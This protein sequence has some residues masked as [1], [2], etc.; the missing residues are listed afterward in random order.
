M[1]A[2]G[3]FC[4]CGANVGAIV[5][6]IVDAIGG[7]LV[8]DVVAITLTTIHNP[9]SATVETNVY[10]VQHYSAPPQCETKC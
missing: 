6:I 3:S 10:Q 8:G 4:A 9:M 7:A 1:R 2:F 5:E